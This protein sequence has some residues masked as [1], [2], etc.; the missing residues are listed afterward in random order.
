MAL[1]ALVEKWDPTTKK[2]PCKLQIHTR[3][4]NVISY[5]EIARRLQEQ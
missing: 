3:R 2:K 5:V 4:K 1:I